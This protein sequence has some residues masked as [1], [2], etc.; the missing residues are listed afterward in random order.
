MAGLLGQRRLV[1]RR[2][3]AFAPARNRILEHLA[4]ER[5]RRLRQVD[6]FANDRPRDDPH[7]RRRRGFLHGVARLKRRD[8]RASFRRRLDDAREQLGRRER[9][10]RVVNDDDT[11]ALRHL[12]ERVRDRILPPR[13]AIDDAHRFAR[14]RS[15]TAGGDRA[16]SGGSAMTISSICSWRSRM[17]KLR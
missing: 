7:A 3:D 9:A 4:V 17:S 2:S 12:R 6:R 8:R 15:E 13:A 11:G 16:R 14:R 5:L 1:G 10:R